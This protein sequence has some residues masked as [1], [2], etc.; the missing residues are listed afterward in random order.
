MQSTPDV[1][2]SLTV[3]P[4]PSRGSVRIALTGAENTSLQIFDMLGKEVYSSSGNS[5]VQ[6]NANASGVY[7]VRATGIDTN[8]EEF[9][10][11]KRLV[12]DR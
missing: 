5:E 11:S 8:G 6:W 4:N 7:I 1:N 10:V 9:I 3:S 2:L 12:I